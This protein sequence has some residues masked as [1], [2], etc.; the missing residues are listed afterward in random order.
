MIKNSLTVAVEQALHPQAHRAEI[1]AAIPSAGS[2]PAP[3][4]ALPAECWVGIDVAKAHLD[5]AIWPTQERWRVPRDEAGLAALI[6]WLQPQTPRLIVLEATG[7][8]ETLVAGMLIEAQFPTAVINPR[9]ARDFA[10]ALGVLAKTDALDALALARF[11]QCIQPQPR[12]WKDEETQALTVLL[13]R[14]RQL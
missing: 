13:Q 12:P 8:L 9:Q 2:L 11:G 4:D 3:T 5:V 6:A 10:K 1:G 14:R 7:G